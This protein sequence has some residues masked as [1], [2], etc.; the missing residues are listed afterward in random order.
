[1]DFN[2]L[3][4]ELKDWNNGKGIDIESW[5]GCIGNFQEAIGYSVIFWPTFVEIE[6]CIVRECV[7]RDNVLQWLKQCKGDCKSAEAMINHFHIEGLHHV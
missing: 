7:P 2:H 5:I 4:P 1:M 3:I 6:G